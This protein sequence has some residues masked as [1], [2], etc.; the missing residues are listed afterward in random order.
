MLAC[1]NPM[2]EATV[3]GANAFLGAHNDNVVFLLR[4]FP[5]IKVSVFNNTEHENQHHQQPWKGY[6]KPN[7]AQCQGVST[8]TFS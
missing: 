7:A 5:A 8:D 1:L 3:F 4:C 2:F 6:G